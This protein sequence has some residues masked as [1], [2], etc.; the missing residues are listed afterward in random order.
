MQGREGERGVL[1]WSTGTGDATWRFAVGCRD[2]RCCVEVCCGVQ[3][4]QRRGCVKACLE[5][6]RREAPH[7]G[8]ELQNLDMYVVAVGR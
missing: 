2:G 5:V 3:G 6:Q 7:E 4:R 1:L 8:C